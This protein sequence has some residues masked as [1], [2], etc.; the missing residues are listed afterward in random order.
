MIRLKK[1]AAAA[2]K[3]DEKMA[4]APK[5][6]GEEK[7]SISASAA[8]GREGDGLEEAQDARRD[9]IQKDIAELD[10]SGRADGFPSERPARLASSWRRTRASGRAR[11]QRR[12][13]SRPCT[14]SRRRSLRYQNLHPTCN[15]GQ[16]LPQ[17]RGRTGSRSSTSTRIYGRSTC[18]PSQP[19]R[20]LK[21]GRAQL[22][23]ATSGD[24]G[25]KSRDAAP[26]DGSQYD[27]DACCSP[28]SPRPWRRRGSAVRS[29]A[30]TGRRRRGRRR[31]RELLVDG[32]IR[33]RVVLS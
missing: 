20:P 7:V 9:P 16:R 21:Q 15:R 2:P 25:E 26:L 12:S 3:E 18:L 33:L 27:K 4:D 17:R 32:A 30:A 14:T 23:G 28:S 19:R 29:A 24:A 8:Q 22:R 10:G 11:L 6:N 31:R 5:A 13:R 1:K